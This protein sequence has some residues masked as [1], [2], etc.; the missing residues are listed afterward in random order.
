MKKLEEGFWAGFL[1]SELFE[2]INENKNRSR[3]IEFSFFG[4]L[5]LF[6]T[7]FLVVGGILAAYPKL[8][9]VAFIVFLVL[10]LTVRV[11]FG[12]I[13]AGILLL[14]PGSLIIVATFFDSPY[15]PEWLIQML[16]ASFGKTCLFSTLA[17]SLAIEIL[18]QLF[19]RGVYFYA[20]KKQ[21]PANKNE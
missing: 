3:G 8:V 20:K 6:A 4:G 21:G 2:W 14:L 18:Y 7:I 5:V 15:C 10:Y 13:R 16:N 1:T 19:I 9:G 12:L 11:E 17:L